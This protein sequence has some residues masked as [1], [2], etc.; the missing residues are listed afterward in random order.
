[1]K[2]TQASEVISWLEGSALVTVAF[3]LLS[4]VMEVQT[5]R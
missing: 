5:K 3:G 2:G 1:M 4:M